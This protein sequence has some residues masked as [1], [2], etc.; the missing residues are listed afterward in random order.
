MRGGTAERCD[1]APKKNS[2][3]VTSVNT[4]GGAAPR[5][6][7]LSFITKVPRVAAAM[8]R[9]V[10]SVN[11]RGGAAPR[12]IYL[13]FITKVPRGAAARSA[14][15]TSVNTR[16]GAAPRSTGAPINV[17][18]YLQETGMWGV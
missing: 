1:G 13:S 9:G 12:S 3:G 7:Y 17:I 6:I 5:S 11:T 2:R 15:D 10:T 16:G 8:S 14:L 18:L 4:R